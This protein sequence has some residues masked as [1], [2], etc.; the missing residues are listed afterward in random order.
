MRALV[1]AATRIVTCCAATLALVGCAAGQISQTSREFSA[2]DGTSGNVGNSIA[3]RDVLIPYPHN[4]M[5]SYPI[6][7]T[8]P[9][10]LSII[11]QGHSSDELVGVDSPAASQVLVEG[12]T[13]VPPGATLTST[14]HA[15]P[16][17]V[18]PTSRLISGELRIVL[19]TNQVLQAGLDTPITFQFQHAGNLTL[20]V[21][22]GAVSDSAAQVGSGGL[23]GI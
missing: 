2:V 12:T 8:V 17:N 1:N 15:A 22:M 20:P 6:G 5:G 16:M 21:P 9:V 7:S 23:T 13:Q 19:T 18:Q 10:L 3:L 11:N 4:R 14:P